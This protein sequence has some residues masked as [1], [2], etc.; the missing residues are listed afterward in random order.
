MKKIIFVIF[1]LFIFNIF[2][3]SLPN[4]KRIKV[5]L[6]VVSPISI[7]LLSPGEIIYS[8]KLNNKNEIIYSEDVILTVKIHK[9]NEIVAVKF[10]KVI[11]LKTPKEPNRYF[12]AKIKDDNF[13][14]ILTKKSNEDIINFHTKLFIKSKHIFH[15]VVGDSVIIFNY[16]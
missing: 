16:N 12:T 1:Y 14:R 8:E 3:F 9:N 13:E 11:N 5:K 15:H 7:S 6:K 2:T 10:P 4:D